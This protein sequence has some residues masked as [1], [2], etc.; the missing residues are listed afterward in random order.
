MVANA[1]EALTGCGY[2][3]ILDIAQ[4]GSGSDPMIATASREGLV[5]IYL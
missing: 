3:T 4:R 1:T 5:R 2:N